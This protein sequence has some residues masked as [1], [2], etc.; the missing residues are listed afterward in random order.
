RY[1]DDDCVAQPGLI[2]AAHGCGDSS[3]NENRGPFGPRSHMYRAWARRYRYG[4]M[5]FGPSAPR[6]ETADGSQAAPMA[7]PAVLRVWSS[8]PRS[9]VM[10][11]GSATPELSVTTS[12]NWAP[13]TEPADTT[14]GLAVIVIIRP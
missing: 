5:R 6:G 14:V 9:Q 12:G 1:G 2:P 3:Q 11:A 7:A 13:A 8:H 4:M 10:P